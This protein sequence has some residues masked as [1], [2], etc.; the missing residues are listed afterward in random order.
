MKYISPEVI[1]ES[2]KKIFYTKDGILNIFIRYPQ[3]LDSITCTALVNNL[4]VNCYN[5]KYH[6]LGRGGIS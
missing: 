3:I 4:Y 6:K 5:E 2:F 1:K